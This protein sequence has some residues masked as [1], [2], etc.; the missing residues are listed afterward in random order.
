M[1]EGKSSFNKEKK[2]TKVN[3]FIYNGK[4]RCVITLRQ[5]PNYDTN[6]TIFKDELS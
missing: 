6:K 4:F 1:N 2:G 5:H 3:Q